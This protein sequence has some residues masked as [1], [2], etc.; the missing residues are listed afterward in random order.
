MNPV[1]LLKRVGWLAAL[2]LLAIT[3]I[4]GSFFIVEPSERAGV[5]V[6][7]TVTTKEPLGPGLHF[8]WPIIS[9]DD[10]IQVSLTTVH[11]KPFE[12]NTVDNQ[13]VSLDINISYSIPDSAVFHLMYDVGRTGGGDI[14][15]A[16]DPIVRDRVSRVFASKNTNFISAEREIIQNEVTK[17]V[18]EA[19]NELFKV[20]VRSLQIASIT[21]SDAF[22][23][24][25]DQAVLAK[26]RA[27]QEE[28]NK[29]VIEYQAQQRVI[30]AEGAA[31]EAI[32]TAEGQARSVELRA[33]ADAK[34]L[35][36]R[37]EAEAA[38]TIIQAQAAKQSI[39]LR[40]A[41]EASALNAVITAS[42]GAPA[43]IAKLQA[44]AQ[45]K[46]TGGVPTIVT[47]DKA[48][49]MMPLILPQSVAAPK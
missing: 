12:V 23:A 45:L 43:Y 8:K 4:F 11:I 33:Q 18:H 21:F 34:A 6:F 13:R 28:N 29:K 10:K 46:W 16:I 15:A 17:V 24:S 3:L 39:E 25:N 44:E 1:V 35:K 32:A 47:S 37:S 49:S 40:G 38:A 42:G 41:G 5:R 14:S 31:R 19:I 26:N 48:G 20:D 36:L 27:V 22:K 9:D 30:A 7:G 2:A